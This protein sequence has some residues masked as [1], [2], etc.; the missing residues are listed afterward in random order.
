MINRKKAIGLLEILTRE[1]VYGGHLLSLGATGVITAS[2]L[3]LDLN[4][5]IAILIIPY[6]SSQLIYSYNHLKEVSFD[7]DSNPERAE[8]IL[9]RK[10]TS[11]LLLFAYSTFLFYSFLFLNL[12]TVIFVSF[13]LISGFIYT[14]YFKRYTARLVVGAKN[15]YS[16]LFWALQVFL[17]PLY[18]NLSFGS[19]YIYLFIILFLTAFI[20]STVFDIK[21]IEADARRGIKTFPVFLGTKNTIAFLSILKLFT[22]IPVLLG[23]Q[24]NI[25]PLESTFFILTT[26]YGLCYLS[27][28][29][30]VS[31]EKLRRLSYVVADG[32]YIL[33]PVL[34]QILVL[35][36]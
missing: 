4:L 27:F 31:G 30:K 29:L 32:E 14:D 16:A 33:W 2:L 8:H 6:L 13:I 11:V 19:E 23:I 25:L 36:L 20:N 17:I 5:D 24:F 28:S 12:N 9:K 34:A 22:I 21:D 10:R 1:F 35:I 3:L 7:K 18:F 26:I 15:F